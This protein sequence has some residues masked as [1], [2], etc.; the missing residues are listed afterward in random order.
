MSWVTAAVMGRVM[1]IWGLL[2]SLQ[3]LGG[4]HPVSPSSPAEGPGSLREGAILEAGWG[5][6]STCL[7]QAQRGVFCHSATLRLPW[8]RA[9]DACSP[10]PVGLDQ[11][12]PVPGLQGRK[13]LCCLSYRVVTLVSGMGCIKGCLPGLEAQGRLGSWDAGFSRP[14]G[15]LRAEVRV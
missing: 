4:P 12:S 15:M 2:R 13:L 7:G 10:V 8:A 3:M 6:L 5:E 14:Q 1:S 9:P 11:A